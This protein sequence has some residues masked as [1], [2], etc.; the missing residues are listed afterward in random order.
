MNAARSTTGWLL[1][2]RPSPSATLVGKIVNVDDFSIRPARGMTANDV[3]NTGKYCYRFY[4][5]PHIPA[6]WDAGVLFEETSK[7]LFCSDLFHHFGNVD[8]ITTSDLIAR[9]ARR[10]SDCSKA[11]WPATCPTRAIPK[12]CL[13]SLAELAPGRPWPSCTVQLH[14]R[15]GATAS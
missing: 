7:T 5:S 2:L 4:R 3:L 8:P 12:A 11:R 13:R 15:E 1:R 9:R 6:R 14:R 10:C